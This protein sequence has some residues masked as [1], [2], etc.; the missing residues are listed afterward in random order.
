MGQV[1]A[2]AHATIAAPADVTFGLIADAAQRP[3]FVPDSFSGFEVLSGGVGAGTVHKFDFQ[4]P[5]RPVRSY[6]MEVSEPEP[7]KVLVETDRNSSLV[8]RF[9]V[10]PQGQQ[11][12]VEITTTWKG[13]G[14]IGGFFEK[15]FAPKALRGIYADEL[16][17]LDAYARTVAG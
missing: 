11:C 1:T 14:G 3:K 4:A 15:T 9:T 2:S 16:T 5:S 6:V 8:T 12:Q 10:T 17:R 7:G 13:A